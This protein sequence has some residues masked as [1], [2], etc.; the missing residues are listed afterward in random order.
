MNKLIQAGRIAYAICIAGIGMQQFQLIAAAVI[1]IA[2]KEAKQTAFL[3]GC[4]FL[5]LFIVNQLPFQ[6]FVAANPFMIGT[7]TNN[8][9]ELT[10]AGGAF[11]AASSYYVVPLQNRSS[12]SAAPKTLLAAGRVFFSITMMVFGIDHFIYTE[13]VAGLVPAWMPGHFF[14]T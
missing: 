4:S 2:S 7:W 5:F 6:L 10:L 3:L 14:W 8:L 12:F 9:K 1:I 11:I 13:F